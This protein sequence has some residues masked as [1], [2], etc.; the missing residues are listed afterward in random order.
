MKLGMDYGDKIA[1]NNCSIT[2]LLLR[3]C[4]RLWS[5]KKVRLIAH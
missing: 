2:E 3:Y 1:R 5:E 4:V